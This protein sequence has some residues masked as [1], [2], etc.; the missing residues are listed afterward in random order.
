[1]KLCHAAVQ[2]PIITLKEVA[3]YLKVHP[4]TVY[5]LIHR[6][7][8]PTFKVGADFRFNRENISE[9]IA[10]KERSEKPPLKRGRR[11]S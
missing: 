1:M 2:S 8:L 6:E 7:D 4:T 10:K 3:E 11:H 5:R 9:W